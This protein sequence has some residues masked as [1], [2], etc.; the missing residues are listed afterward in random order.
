MGDDGLCQQ[1]LR[2]RGGYER[3]GEIWKRHQQR[4]R[5]DAVSR[6]GFAKIVSEAIGRQSSAFDAQAGV[7]ALFTAVDIDEAGW[8]TWDAFFAHLMELSRQEATKDPGTMAGQVKYFTEATDAL[9][10]DASPGQRHPLKHLRFWPQWG[11]MTG[12]VGGRLKVLHPRTCQVLESVKMLDEGTFGGLNAVECL[13]GSLLS[14]LSQ[15]VDRDCA[16]LVV[17]G[18]DLTLRVLAM[19]GS[20]TVTY[21][22]DAPSVSALCSVGCHVPRRN[23]DAIVP[24]MLYA[25]HRSGEV[26]GVDVSA[27][28][29]EL[30]GVPRGAAAAGLV[31]P[32]RRHYRRCALHSRLS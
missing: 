24:S 17:A 20:Q 22:F 27:L 25:A 31:L 5:G 19:P 29:A 26:S 12:V 7:G 9:S 3:L 11:R 10:D 14:G 23:T 18:G 30:G 1:L 15:K 4:R 32:A 13:S 6:D 8:I 16:A 21:R 2:C 28:L